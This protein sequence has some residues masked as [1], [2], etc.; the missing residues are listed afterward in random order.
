METPNPEHVM[1][2]PG[3]SRMTVHEQVVQFLKNAAFCDDCIASKLGLPK[4]QQVQQ[5][6][7]GLR[8]GSPSFKRAQGTCVLCGKVKKVVRAN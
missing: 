4:R 7:E 5:V 2:I 6:T 3:R 1:V 8:A